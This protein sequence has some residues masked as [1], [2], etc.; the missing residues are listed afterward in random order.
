MGSLNP[1][2]HQAILFPVKLPDSGFDRT[3][4]PRSSYKQRDSLGRS[5]Y[6][7]DATL[8]EMINITK[9]GA[10]PRQWQEFV[11]TTKARYDQL[12]LRKTELEKLPKT[13]NPLKRVAK[14][15]AVRLFFASSKS[16]YN[17]T[18]SRSDEM[19]RTMARTAGRALLSVPCDDMQRVEDDPSPSVDLAG[20][21]VK[22]DRP[23]DET[24]G[25]Q[26]INAVNTIASYSGPFGEDEAAFEVSSVLSQE[27]FMASESLISG[28]EEE[29]PDIPT[30]PSNLTS[31]ISI[32]HHNYYGCITSINST[33][34]GQTTQFG[35]HG[36]SGSVNHDIK[37][38]SS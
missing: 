22:L 15:R 30:P 25:Q 19:V 2:Q 21:A 11:D 34:T 3:L 36:N 32:T 6:Y 13:W 8:E 12:T 37:T 24:I 23:Y 18:K 4:F 16:L 33:F 28:A 10:N 38:T 14:Y 26:V 20:I 1:H 5:E 7:L 35:G 27:Y 29:T 9:I 17:Q 31:S